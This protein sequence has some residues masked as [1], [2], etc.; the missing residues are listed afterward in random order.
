MSAAGL[1]SWLALPAEE[2]DE[3]A[4][5]LPP[6]APQPPWVLPRPAA[7]AGGGTGATAPL[8]LLSAP[9]LGMACCAG[10]LCAASCTSLLRGFVSAVGPRRPR[11]AARHVL[12]DGS[13][14]ELV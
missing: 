8:W 2:E 3:A 7:G 14:Y 10:M 13:G 1:P 11:L 9:A 6:S 4:R 12:R 5:A